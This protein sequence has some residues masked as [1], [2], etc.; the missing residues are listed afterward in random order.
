MPHSPFINSIN[1]LSLFRS[2]IYISLL[3]TFSNLFIRS[4]FKWS[5]QS[6]HA[7]YLR[8]IISVY[9]SNG[10]SANSIQCIDTSENPFNIYRKSPVWTLEYFF[11]V[12]YL[13][14]LEATSSLQCISVLLL[15]QRPEVIVCPAETGREVIT[16]EIITPSLSFQEFGIDKFSSGED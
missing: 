12:S 2:N 1:I 10:C 6:L 11:S 14:K 3:Q 8:N 7:D 13:F 9:L 5:F 15:Q 16:Q 4:Q